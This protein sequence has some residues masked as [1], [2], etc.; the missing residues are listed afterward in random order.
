[1]LNTFKFVPLLLL[2]FISGEVWATEYHVAKQGSDQHEG[3]SARPFET[4]QVAAA[5]AQPGDTITVH[6]GIYREYVNPPRGGS[7]DIRRI[8]YRAAAGEK[9]EIR[10]SETI[11]Q[12]EKTSDGIWRVKIP[13]T[14]FGSYNPYRDT[15]TGDWLSKKGI[16]HHTGE[17]YLNDVALFERNT[18]EEVIRP[19]PYPDAQDQKA[20]T[21]VWYC[22]ST[23]DSTTLW[24]NFQNYDPNRERVE[25]NARASCFYPDRPGRNYITVR[26]FH[27]SQAA[28]QWAAPTAEQIGLIGTHWSK[29]W[30]I[31]NNVISHSKSVG[32]TLG[33][34]RQ[35]G[36]NV[37]S[38]NPSKD[39]ATHY[40]EVIFKALWAGWSA[41]KIG[42]HV[43]RN[44]VI[45]DC[46][47]AGIVGSLGA[48]FSQIYDNH[49]YDIWTRR[50]FTGA[51][52][53]GIKI[54]AAID[55]LIRQNRVNNTGRGIWLD[56]MA[57]GTRVTANLLYDNT[58][59]DLFCEVNHGPYL[60]D[61]NI[62][63]SEI[64]IKDWSEG[65]AFVH[66]LIGGK[67]SRKLV[68]DRFT[69]YH[70]PHSTKVAGLRNIVGSD[71][72]FYNNIFAKYN[73]GL[74]G[75]QDAEFYGLSGYAEAEFPIQ[76]AGNLFL[77]GAAP[78]ILTSGI[79]KRNF[80]PNI[81]LEEKGDSVLLYMTLPNLSANI[82]PA[83]VTTNLL[84]TT[85]ISNAIFEQPDGM[86]LSID[87]DY[88]GNQRKPTNLSPGP[89]SSL[90][91]DSRAYRV[92]Y[93]R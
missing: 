19:T 36:H 38:Q 91:Q 1:M 53:A 86:S 21:Y 30:V 40:N 2:V 74:A 5:V 80:D 71:N 68:A 61:N 90:K 3:S 4:I 28:T 44:N 20:S 49:I 10:G 88:F 11:D 89:F 13:N 81:R 16:N 15:L 33:K 76:A 32:I 55:V 31:E 50:T 47:Q 41:E 18:L 22:E 39:G 34:D 83:L 58:T 52:M 93:Q 72:R 42:S 26:G 65:G 56:W 77:N 85:Q 79:V 69:P 67:I 27:M 45:R 35:S 66:N 48:I 59:D 12:W 46:G 78:L 25:I 62:L 57:Q 73:G 70:L 9:V 82:L 54:H 23:N 37:W 7:S 6:A 87:E 60:V 14:F 92:W 51:E 84:G 43:V 63:L 17:V 64:A 75:R 8:V 29:G 24:A